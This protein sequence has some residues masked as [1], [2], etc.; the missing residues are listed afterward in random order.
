MQSTTFL[1]Y[2]KC[3]SIY[4]GFSEQAWV[5]E[6]AASVQSEWCPPGLSFSETVAATRY[7]DDLALVSS[8]LC[9]ACLNKLPGYMY[10][11]PII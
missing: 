1:S 8:S 7:V 11:K 6:M 9:A 4:L 3:A 5:Q 2:Y 10:E